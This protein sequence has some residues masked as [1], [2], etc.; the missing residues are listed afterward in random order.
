MKKKLLMIAMSLCMVLTCM[1]QTLST[2]F[3]AETGSDTTV[4]EPQQAA[5]R[6][7]HDCGYHRPEGICVSIP[8]RPNKQTYRR[9]VQNAD[10]AQTVSEPI[11]GASLE[12]DET[13]DRI[14][15]DYLRKLQ[16]ANNTS[17]VYAYEKIAK[18]IDCHEDSVEFAVDENVGITSKEADMVYYLVKE[19]YPEFF[20]WGNGAPTYYVYKESNNIAE[21]ELVGTDPDSEG[22]ITNV[23]TFA[24]RGEIEAAKAKFD[25]TV[26]E[27]VAQTAQMNKYESELFFH[28]WI[29]L[30]NYY[31][32][33]FS[34]PHNHDA[35][36]A[37]VDGVAVCEG[38]TRAM[39]VLLNKRDI[40]NYTV[41]GTSRNSA[42]EEV[43]HTWNVVELDDGKWYQVDATWD[44][45]GDKESDIFYAYFNIT[46]DQMKND[47][48]IPGKDDK[49]YPNYVIYEC[50][51]TTY[52]Y[53]T[54]NPDFVVTVWATIDE[55]DF[56][57]KLE[58]Q[59]KE[60]IIYAR[61][62]AVGDNSKDA[63]LGNLFDD[64]SAEKILENRNFLGS[65]STIYSSMGEMEYHFVLQYESNIYGY[66]EQG[67]VSDNKVTIRFYPDGTEYSEI[68]EK[69]QLPEGKGS[70]Q[71]DLCVEAVTNIAPGW[72]DRNDPEKK[73][74]YGT[75]RKDF[76]ARLLAG[77]YVM[78]VYIEGQGCYSS[79]VFVGKEAKTEDTAEENRWLFYKLGDLDDN[80]IVDVSDALFL[81]RYIAE[82]DNYLKNG[83]W[84]AADI[85]D[86]EKIDIVD[87][88][89]LRRHLAGWT[90]F[91][92]LE[93]YENGDKQLTNTQNA[94]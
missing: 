72:T 40:K 41:S 6:E 76:S 75:Y 56:I 59:F 22:K 15:K 53:Y 44:D 43:G 12:T 5:D 13:K 79:Y 57:N 71:D 26:N 77:E 16:G 91:E 48:T 86:D 62:Y 84:C 55:A 83:N 68:V 54:Q 60:N 74:Y 23:Y 93:D 81:T 69:I 35:Y 90:D 24:T 27:I 70:G 78:A 85:N 42:G 58:K 33:T 39:Q 28:D 94:A 1:P 19:D 65:Y 38:Y 32:D 46:T 45:Q 36:G 80:S 64:S 34:K 11:S 66:L 10:P 7:G 21:I 82:W 3:A 25:A 51:S 30:N 61:I 67:K 2:A 4:S 29:A 8:E 37:I 49:N 18:A 47:H 87:L 9:A 88:T 31:D 20:W 89:I 52:W 73:K 17:L 50:N 92:N 14:G 63:V